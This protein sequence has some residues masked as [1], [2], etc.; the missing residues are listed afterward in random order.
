MK[1][2]GRL[3]A[4]QVDVKLSGSVVVLR[5]AGHCTSAGTT[6]RVSGATAEM[7][8][9]TRLVPHGGIGQ[10]SKY[11]EGNKDQFSCYWKKEVQIY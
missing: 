9:V 3:V 2:G 4:E 7:A 10:I 1:G 6:G 5:S 8:F 11:V